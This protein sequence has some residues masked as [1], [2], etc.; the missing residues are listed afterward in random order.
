M[1]LTVLLVSIFKL[2]DRKIKFYCLIHLL[3]IISLVI[4]LAHTFFMSKPK[5]G[6]KVVK[7]VVKIIIEPVGCVNGGIEI[8]QDDLSENIGVYATIQ[9][10]LD[11]WRSQ[12]D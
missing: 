12:V 8:G 10:V 1:A 3:D 6:K 4:L 5:Y 11:S 2:Y 9:V 7:T